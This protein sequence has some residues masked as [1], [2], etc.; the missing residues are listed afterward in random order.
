MVFE[1]KIHVEQTISDQIPMVRRHFMSKTEGTTAKVAAGPGGS[2]DL[3][4]LLGFEPL[5]P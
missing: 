4:N 1:L 2:P 3:A 5:S